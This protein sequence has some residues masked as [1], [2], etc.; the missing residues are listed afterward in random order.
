MQR[1]PARTRSPHCRG[2]RAPGRGGRHAVR[3]SWPPTPRATPP[4]GALEA[5]ANEVSGWVLPG[6]LAAVVAIVGATPTSR[7]LRLAGRE[8]IAAGSVAGMVIGDAVPGAG[9][10]IRV[11]AE[12]LASLATTE[13][14]PP[15][16]LTAAEG[17]VVLAETVQE[18]HKVAWLVSAAIDGYIDIEGAGKD[19]TLVRLPRDDGSAARILDVA[20]AAESACRSAA[21]TRVLLRPGSHCR[22]AGG[23]G[24]GER[25]MG[26]RR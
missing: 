25:P 11:D 17:G 3:I 7:F 14:A 19:T 23:V 26:R 1:R 8:R 22:P 9:D 2:R 15:S 24:A 4:G 12:E 5:L 13:V 18:E 6:L 21:T 10:E 16:E 20:F